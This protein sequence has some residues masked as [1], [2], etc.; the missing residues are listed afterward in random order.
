MVNFWK[1]FK[2]NDVVINEAVW[3]HNKKFI[4]DKMYGNTYCPIIEVHPI[5]ENKT[6][7]NTCLFSVDGTK[8]ADCWKRPLKKLQKDRVIKLMKK[9]N[10]EAKREFLIRIFNKELMK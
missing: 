3:G 10:V 1:Y 9:G 6:N 2:V 5:S 4:V 7:G 8:L